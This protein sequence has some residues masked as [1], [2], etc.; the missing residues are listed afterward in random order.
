MNCGLPLAG[1]LRG[2]RFLKRRRAQRRHG[3]RNSCGLRAKAQL[4]K[5]FRIELP[6]RIQPM[7]FLEF[8]GR[9]ICRSVPFSVRLSAERT[10]FSE[11]LLDL[12][13]AVGCGNFL[14]PLPPAGSPRISFSV[15]GGPGFGGN[16][17]LMR[18]ALRL[19]RTSEHT[20]PRRKEQRRGQVGRFSD[21]HS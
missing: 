14:P 13:N 7:R 5:G 11:R 15:R 12:G 4:L 2:C 9:F 10:V 3:R 21:S 19:P 20:Q 17:F 6:R 1:R 16:G 8:S 18:S